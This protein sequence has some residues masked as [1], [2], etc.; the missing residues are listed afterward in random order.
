[1]KNWAG[2]VEYTAT[3]ITHPAT[4][5]EL[6]TQVSNASTVRSLGS[7]HSFTDIVD[8]PTMINTLALGEHLEIGLDRTEVTVNASMTYGRLCELLAPL[9]FA[10]HNLASLPHISIAGAISTGTHGSGRSNGNLATSVAALELATSSGEVGWLRQ[11]DDDLPGAVVGLGALGVLTKVTLAVEPAFDVCQHV[12]DDLDQA[13]FGENVN[14][15]MTSGYSVSGFT[16]WNG[17]VEQVWIKRR[18][19]TDG[20]PGDDLFG[21]P[22]A[23]ENRHP[24]RGVDA[25]AATQQLGI[26]GSWADRLP[27]FRL[28]FSPSAGDEIQSEFFVR[29]SDARPVLDAM[30]AIGPRLAN[31]LLVSEIRSTS[32]DQ[33]WMS[34]NHDRDTM[35]LH[36]TW[37]PDQESA[38]TAA[39]LVGDVLAEFDARTHWGKVFAPRHANLDSYSRVHDFVDLTR[40]FDPRGAFRNEWFERVFGGL[41]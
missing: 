28:D 32:G 37:G 24:I 20:H 6:A 30:H 3:E 40:R 15:I 10:V 22:P 9:G 25:A 7:G 39:T 17:M 33:L 12:F 34:P 1:M 13:T 36:F 23:I 29:W 2:N 41:A 4:V 21:A 5:A 8:A 35:A 11:G 14:A 18:V 19:D 31:A 38:E 27:H 16:R 26:P